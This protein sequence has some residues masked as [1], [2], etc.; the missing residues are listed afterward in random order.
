MNVLRFPDGQPMSSGVTFGNIFEEGRRED[1]YE[2]PVS[3]I[4]TRA[5][6]FLMPEWLANIVGFRGYDTISN[7]RTARFVAERPK[8][9]FAR[10]KM[11]AYRL[12]PHSISL[13][14]D[15]IQP[16][17]IGSV[18]SKILR[19]LPIQHKFSRRQPSFT[20][21]PKNLEYH[22]IA[23]RELNMLNFQLLDMAGNEIEFA[24]E[25]QNVILGLVLKMIN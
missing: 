15:F 6:E 21:E 18:Q 7:G 12:V 1:D 20:F 23:T 24:N 2:G 8:I 9:I 17:L 13:L 25:N 19:T 11:D 3:M 22:N 16:C 14:A 5:C 10:A 4:F